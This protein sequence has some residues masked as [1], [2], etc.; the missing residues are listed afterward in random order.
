MVLLRFRT[1]LWLVM[2]VTVKQLQCG[3]TRTERPSLRILPQLAAGT[4]WQ[5]QRSAQSHPSCVGVTAGKIVNTTL[6][7]FASVSKQA[8]RAGPASCRISASG[9][10]RLFESDVFE[11]ASGAA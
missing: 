1:F 10:P 7:R 6:D 3:T 5:Y 2:V 4:K 8:A 11:S 9:V